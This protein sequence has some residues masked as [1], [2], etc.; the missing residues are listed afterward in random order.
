VSRRPELDDLDRE[1]REHIEEETEDNIARGM[2]A[3]AARHAAHRKFGNLARVKEQVRAVW[4]PEWS[5]RAAQ[6]ARD[7]VRR[8]RRNPV[9]AMAITLT[10]ALGI[11][12]T[13][14]VYSV[15]DAVVLKPLS[16]PH[17][18]RVVWLTTVTERSNAEIMNAIDF[19]EW[20]AQAA[21]FEHMVA[22]T[23]SDATVAVAGEA[24][25]LRVVSASSG[26]WELTGARPLFG[27]LPAPAD[28]QVLVLTHRAFRERFRSDPSVVGQAIMLDGQPVTLGA[29]LPADFRPQLPGFAWRPGQDRFEPDAYRTMVVQ[30]PSRSGNRSGMVAVLLA[31]GQLKPDVTIDQARA[32]VEA[33]HRRN[34]Q[35]GPPV[36][37]VSK[38]LLVPLADRL[39]GS[40]RFALA[41]LLAAAGCVLLI[42]CVNVANLLMS[43]ASARQK[44][45]ALRISIGSGPLRVV[46]QLLAESV[47]YSLLGGAAGLVLAAWLVNVVVA[48]IGP[49]VPRLSEAAVDLRVLA[50][51][52]VTSLAAALLFGLGP[53]I[54]LCRTNVQDVL[55]EGVRSASASPRARLAGRTMIAVQ[56]AVTVVLVAAAG[57]M[58]KS[59]WRMTSYP[60]GFDPDRILTMR[61]DF[62]GP[63]YRDPRARHTYA[64]ALL[65]RARTLPGVRDAA[66][67]SGRDTTMVVFKEGDPFPDPTTRRTAVVSRVS[68]RFGPLIGM[69]IVRGGWFNDA[70]TTNVVLIN[71]SL[72]RRDYPDVDPLGRRI[73]LPWLGDQGFATIVGVVSDLKY[74]R[75]DADAEPEV[76]FPYLQS[77]VSGVTIALRVDG[78]PLDQSPAITKALAAVDPT[79]SVFSVRT[80]EQALAES[81]APRRFNLLVLSTFAVVALVLAVLGVYGVV[82][83]AVAERTHEIGIRLALGADR[84]RVIA[85][86][87]GEGMTNVAFGILIGIIAAVFATRLIDQLIYGVG[88]G[89]PATFALTTAAMA[90]AAFAACAVPALKAAGV[91][92]VSALRAQ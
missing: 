8:I 64:A 83:Y 29:V 45:I 26:F 77:P 19:A 36:F 6:D 21:T 88:I 4:V 34:Q 84:R 74:A 56:L 51:A 20:K 44:E 32:D 12:L 1:M 9:F 43:R 59:V 68:S 61:V 31:I 73:R 37:G 38:P 85:M 17:P 76:F 33:L 67:T 91:D 54:T 70:E 25:R 15:V 3:V 82:A 63:Q 60:D 13:T 58:L 11:G 65:E 50:F 71:E 41:I 62:R 81:I 24:S 39:V 57:L 30:A 87:I 46:R 42:T 27:S 5:D 80:M 48:L 75:I 16:Y 55:K 7:A 47:A 79:Q 78:N 52:F 72:A 86:I 35:P 2:T 40:S 89:D 28:R 18:D 90:A 49:A 92:P 10:L 22:Y 14:A 23:Q 69:P 53:A 66:I